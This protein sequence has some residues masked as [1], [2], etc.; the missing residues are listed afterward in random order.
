MNRTPKI[1][2]NRIL[3]PVAWLKHLYQRDIITTDIVIIDNI[4]H[5]CACYPAGGV[6]NCGHPFINKKPFIIRGC[7][8]VSDSQ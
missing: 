7:K 6:C 4:E 8:K 3:A 2:S 1:F 5:T